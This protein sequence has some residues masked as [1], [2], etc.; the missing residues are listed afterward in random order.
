MLTFKCPRACSLA[1]LCSM[2]WPLVTLQRKSNQPP[3]HVLWT[4]SELFQDIGICLTYDYLSLKKAIQ[5]LMTFC[6]TKSSNVSKI[7]LIAAKKIW[8]RVKR[9]AQTKTQGVLIS[10]GWYSNQGLLWIKFDEEKKIDDPTK[11][12]TITTLESRFCSFWIW[13][14]PLVN[15]SNSITS[16]KYSRR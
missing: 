14:F 8:D 4:L 12:S 2:L 3:T 7:D 15:V 11:R 16:W 9:Y 10:G 1:C 6:R 13:K 5:C